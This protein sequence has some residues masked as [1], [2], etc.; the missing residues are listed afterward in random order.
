MG[1]I[2][3]LSVRLQ[4]QQ[5]LS[6]GIAAV[7][8]SLQLQW[9]FSVGTAAALTAAITIAAVGRGSPA[10]GRVEQQPGGRA[11]LHREDAHALEGGT[12]CRRR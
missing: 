11:E 10:L 7:S 1:M 2:A 8:V 3:A 12:A 9:G 6:V 5:G 4:L